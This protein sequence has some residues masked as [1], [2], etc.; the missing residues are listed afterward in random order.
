M[1]TKVAQKTDEAKKM[2]REI[3]RDYAIFAIALALAVLL[4]LIFPDRKA[5][6]TI[7]AWNYFLEMIAIMPAVMIIMGLFNVFVSKE[8]VVKYLG[9]TSGIKGILLAIFFGAL[10][11]GPLYIAFPLSLALWKK[12]ARVSNI[13]IFLSAWACIKI[14][15]ELV[16]LQFLGLKFM[17]ARLTLTV[18]FVILMGLFIEKLMAHSDQHLKESQE[19][20]KINEGI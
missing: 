11:T 20:G 13:V 9:K 4:L 19:G 1:N 12:G 6:A 8:Q 15:Q 10:P 18:V 2:R 3:I 7:T 17:A 16:E 5:T 14:P